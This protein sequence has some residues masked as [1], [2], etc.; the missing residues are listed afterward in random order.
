VHG[1]ADSVELNTPYYGLRQIFCNIFHLPGGSERDWSAI[2]PELQPY[3]PLLN[4]I[5]PLSLPENAVTLAMN[6]EARADMINTLLTSIIHDA[7]AQLGNK[8]ILSVEDAQ[9]LDSA[10]WSALWSIQNTLRN[11]L[12]IVVS[13]SVHNP[14]AAMQKMLEAAWNNDD[15]V[16]LIQ[17]TP[18]SETHVVEVAC[19]QLHIKSFPS[20]ISKYIV[21][22]AEG[23]P[24]FVIELV[25]SLL[26]NNIIS[27]EGGECRA[28]DKF[29]K[30]VF[31][32]QLPD[33]IQGIIAARINKLS[34]SQ[35]DVL[36][37]ASVIGHVF[38][39][40]TVQDVLMASENSVVIKVPQTLD[41]LMQ[42]DFIMLYSETPILYRFKHFLVQ[43]GVYDLMLVSQRMDLHSQV[44]GWC[45][46]QGVGG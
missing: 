10:S 13:R 18:L 28:Q 2:Q 35:L 7:A 31:D 4:S 32:I 19:A 24:L 5:T 20:E 16:T 40:K 39:Q 46:Y 6:T 12:L 36:K 1:A 27:L 44:G 22:K 21:E 30:G 23:N 26:D 43:E 3:L 14:S 9:W 45:R 8:L 38:S 42:L 15:R 29:K 34:Q 41:V 37:I 17:M 25:F 11:V 33:T